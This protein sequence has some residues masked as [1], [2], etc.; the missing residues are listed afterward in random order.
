MPDSA[1][2]RELVSR[3][4]GALLHAEEY[5]CMGTPQ[6]RGQ[7]RATKRC[8]LGEMWLAGGPSPKSGPLQ[9]T[10]RI[11]R[12]TGD[13]PEAQQLLSRG[14]RRAQLQASVRPAITLSGSP[15]Q[16]AARAERDTRRCT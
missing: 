11:E 9:I 14:Q 5:L 15:L 1:W 3:A 12:A 6:C 13:T 2:S 8:G 7:A 10:E 16:V 4:L